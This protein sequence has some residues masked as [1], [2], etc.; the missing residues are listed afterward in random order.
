MLFRSL[1]L[2]VALSH[3]ARLLVLDEPTSGLDP[4][5]RD[6]ICDI[7]QDFVLDDRKSVLF[8]THITSDLEKIADY[9]VFILDGR[10]VFSGLKE[11]LMAKYCAVKG[12]SDDITQEQAKMIIGLRQHPTGFEGMIAVEKTGGLSK[13][14][15][16]EPI[17]LEDIIIYMNREAYDE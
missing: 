2:A 17:S 11:E 8:S 16:L 15:L 10:V 14:L 9:I 1:M 7:L 6:E 13:D 3:D 5:A 4:S 12:G